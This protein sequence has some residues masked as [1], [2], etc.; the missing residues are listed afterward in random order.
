MHTFT[1]TDVSGGAVSWSVGGTNSAIF[2]IDANG[3][4][5]FQDG[6]K[7]AYDAGG[8]NTYE[9]TVEASDATVMRTA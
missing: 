1:A 7:P 6:S 5:S 3:A 2:E 9:I 4:L 8:A